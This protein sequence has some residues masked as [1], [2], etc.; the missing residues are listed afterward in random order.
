MGGYI[1]IIYNIYIYYIYITYALVYVTPITLLQLPVLAPVRMVALVQEL[2]SAL[3]PQ[4]GEEYCVKQ[5]GWF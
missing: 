5:V 4:D 2:T 3:V 1:Y